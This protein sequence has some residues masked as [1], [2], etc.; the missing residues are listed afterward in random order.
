[1]IINASVITWDNRI[2]FHV[3]FQINSQVQYIRVL[4]V[5][6]AVMPCAHGCAAKEIRVI[7]D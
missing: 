1:M 6:V 4:F 2:V 7:R 5:R 3:F